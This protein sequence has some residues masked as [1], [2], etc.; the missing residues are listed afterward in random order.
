MH[1]KVHCRR[2]G[3]MNGSGQTP[4]ELAHTNYYEMVC[5]SWIFPRM[6]CNLFLTTTHQKHTRKQVNPIQHTQSKVHSPKR[7]CLKRASGP[8]CPLVKVSDSVNRQ[9]HLSVRAFYVVDTGKTNLKKKKERKKDMFRMM[10][11]HLVSRCLICLLTAF[12]SCCNKEN[13][14]AVAACCP[15]LFLSFYPLC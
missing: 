3:G 6:N 8:L 2:P 15:C 10:K 12:V 7:C 9:F 4:S 1:D 5:F 14:Q 13:K 11:L